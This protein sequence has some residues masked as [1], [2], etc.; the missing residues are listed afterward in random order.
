MGLL[1]SSV[2]Y[3][4]DATDAQLVMGVIFASV[5]C[6]SWGLSAQIPT[7]MA[8]REVFYKQRGANF[9]RTASY[10]LYAFVS[11]IPPI[12]LESV[13]FGSIVYW[14]C[15]FVDTIGAY[16]LFMLM[17]CM[18]SI[19]F[20]AFFFFLASASPNFNIANPIAAVSMLLF[21][22]FGGF[23]TTKEQIPDYLIWIYWINPIAWCVRALAVNQYRDSSFDTCVYDG[24]NFCENY[25]QTM[26]DYSLSTFEVPTAKYWLWYGIVYM[27]A[28]YIFFTFLSY[29]AL[30]Y[31]R[32]ES[33]ENVVLDTE[34]KGDITDSYLS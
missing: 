6:L 31:C 10:V 24:I 12:I 9:F 22:L 3:Q 20:T 15:G 27:A 2:F 25:N 13:V 8:A 23:V 16:I 33:P 29:L 18:T 26:G 7:V 17:L 19:A 30:E 32:Y 4:L 21:I 28:A 5:L 1:Y 34:D 11:Q 14:M